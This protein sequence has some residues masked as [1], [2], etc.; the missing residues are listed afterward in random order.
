MPHNLN[1]PSAEFVGDLMQGSAEDR[2]WRSRSVAPSDIA[3]VMGRSPFQ[4]REDLL[5]R[6][7]TDGTRPPLKRPA[8]PGLG[9]DKQPE[10]AAD[11]AEEHSE[12]RVVT[13]G[14]WVSTERPWQRC[15]PHR[16]LVPADYDPTCGGS[17]APIIATLTFRTTSASLDDKSWGP[18]GSALIP[19]ADYDHHQ[20]L[21]DTYGLDYGYVM[22][23]S[24]STGETRTY[25][26]VRNV[27]RIAALRTAA[28]AFLRELPIRREGDHG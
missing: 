2:A 21:L 10:L 3:A 17:A 6:K 23:Y 11:F 27:E 5:R 14:Y 13:T 16:V 8:Q 22:A 20:W 24:S 1:A 12:Y 4:T 28:E 9:W 18:D 26:I 25:R 15:W 7:A 19:L